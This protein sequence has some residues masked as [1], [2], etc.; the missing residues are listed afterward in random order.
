MDWKE[1]LG[2]ARQ[3]KRLSR[4]SVSNGL[5]TS[6]ANEYARAFCRNYYAVHM[7]FRDSSVHAEVCISL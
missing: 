5:E 7:D 4:N 3:Y 2:F 6:A 1:A